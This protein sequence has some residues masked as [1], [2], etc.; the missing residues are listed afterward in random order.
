MGAK[1]LVPATGY[2]PAIGQYLPMDSISP[3]A[4]IRGP[5]STIWPENLFTAQ[6]TDW[7]VIHRELS[8]VAAVR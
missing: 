6:I 5:T 4:L 1:F 8:L 3:A 7:I 2:V